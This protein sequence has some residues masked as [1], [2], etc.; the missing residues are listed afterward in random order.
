MHTSGVG[1]HENDT[2]DAG[3][4]FEVGDLVRR[5]AALQDFQDVKDPL[6]QKAIWQRYEYEHRPIATRA[7][8]KTDPEELRLRA[9]SKL[10][11]DEAQFR[12]RWTEAKKEI[13]EALSDEK[14]GYNDDTYVA[15]C[16]TD[17][18]KQEVS[19]YI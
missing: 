6:L 8:K 19:T 16:Y 18:A 7:T 5:E 9:E 11:R 14:W 3:A 12:K 2:N 1:T 17:N 15:A 13:R 10:K 4:V